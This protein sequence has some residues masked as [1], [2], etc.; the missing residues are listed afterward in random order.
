MNSTPYRGRFAPSPTGPLHFGSLVAAA[1]SYLDARASNGEWL[2]RMEDVD[3]PRCSA[4]YDKAIMLSLEAYGFEWHGSVMRQSERTAAYQDAFNILKRKNLVYPCAC[5]RKE[6]SD[7]AIAP[8]GAHIYP[9]TCINGLEEGKTA[10]SWRIAV[11]GQHIRFF[12]LIQGSVS[13]ALEK[14]VGDFIILRADGYFAY[15]LAVVVDDAEQ[16]ITRIV[17]GADLLHSTPRQICLQHH[18]GFHVAEYAHLPVAVN[19]QGEKLS[20][21]T[22]ATPLNDSNPVP[23]LISAFSFLGMTSLKENN[24]SLDDLWNQAIQCWSLSKVPK[25]RSIQIKAVQERGG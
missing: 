6:I 1:G 20:K 25:Q 2:V 8:D 22:L 15:H 21:Q 14:E 16:G 24:T 18:L 5:S 13:Q 17:R 19:V 4:E 7:S 12:D 23:A 10:H 3:Q 11:S 9:G